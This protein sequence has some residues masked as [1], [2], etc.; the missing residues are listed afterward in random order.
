MLKVNLDKDRSLV[1]LEP[2]GELTEGDFLTASRIIDPYIETYGNLRGII[3]YVKDFPQWD[4]F[5]ALITHLNFVK[6][7]HK[8][9]S[10][11]A[12]V[13]DSIIGDFAE[14]F[15]SHFI[16]AKIKNFDYDELNKA[17]SWIIDDDYITH[18]LY[19]SCET[20][21]NGIYMK[22]KTI[23]TLTHEDYE[24]ITPI[25]DSVLEEMN[26]SK[27]DILVDIEQL[28]GWELK[29]AWDDLKLGLKHGKKFNKI[30][31]YG[32]INWQDL[33]TK[34]GSWFVGGEIKSFD[35]LEDA[36]LWLDNK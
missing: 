14:N 25:I 2:N 15:A 33:A 9:V 5:S 27:I 24:R 18:G 8:K 7:H 32:H 28:E 21:N 10:H 22:F 29:A 19:L 13:T 1:V 12:F 35:S 16:K 30:A 4:S 3:I 36:M 26:E 11:V 23:G 17:K 34:I 31:I 20:S 6:E